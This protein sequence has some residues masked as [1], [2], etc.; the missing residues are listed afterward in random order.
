MIS[1]ILAVAAR[2]LLPLLMLFS[3]FLL[4]RGHNEPGGG[5]AG[6]LVLAAAIALYAIAN[7]ARQTR[8]LL[9][10]DPFVLMG[11]GLLFAAA[12]GL[13][14]LVQGQPFLQ[15]QWITVPLPVFGYVKVGSPL[16]FDLGVYFVVMSV[17]QTILL[18]LAE[19]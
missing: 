19:E 15:G 4:F 9:R 7:G 11:I 10:F 2:Y 14:A 12:S 18:T 13:P 1:L 6:G 8:R 3:I 17:S 16:L 5:F